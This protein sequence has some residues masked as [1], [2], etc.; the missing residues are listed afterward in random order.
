MWRAIALVLLAAVV[1]FAVVVARQPADFAIQR[2]IVVQAPP[3]VIYPHIA[4]PRAMNEWSPFALGDPQMKIEYS[5][6]E[7]GVDAKSAWDSKQ[8]GAGSMTYTE[9]KPDQEVAMRLDFERPMKAT[10]T[11]R[12]SLEPAGSTTRVTWRMEGHNGFVG[13]AFALVM[14]MDKVVGGEF[15][16]GLLEL[17]QKAEAEAAGSS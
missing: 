6:P 14:N 13:K 17:K 3:S 1:I 10:N 5:G 7:T 2:T 4:G 12:I 8:M 16:K 11:A 15:E 9:A